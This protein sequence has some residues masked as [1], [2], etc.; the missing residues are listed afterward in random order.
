M[1]ILFFVNLLE[2]FDKNLE[3]GL[4]RLLI[5]SFDK[6]TRLHKILIA[7]QD[8]ISKKS[9]LSW[10]KAMRQP[11]SLIEKMEVTVSKAKNSELSESF[12]EY[13]SHLFRFEA[14]LHRISTKDNAIIETPEY[15]KKGISK[16]G[17]TSTLS[18]ID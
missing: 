10:L 18:N 13:K 5:K 15:I 3:N 1:I 17:L 7:K 2:R 8:Q 12:K 6:L 4:I 9:A 16:M 11:L 14:V